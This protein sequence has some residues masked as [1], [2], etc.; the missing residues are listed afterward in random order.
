MFVVELYLLF[1]AAQRVQRASITLYPA[2][3]IIPSSLT[4][5]WTLFILDLS[6]TAMFV[7]VQ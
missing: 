1:G 7:A 3:L 4:S 2:V 6:L 5:F